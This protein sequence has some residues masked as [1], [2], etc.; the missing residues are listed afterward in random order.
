MLNERLKSDRGD[1]LSRFPHHIRVQIGD[2]L[3]KWVLPIRL[4]YLTI[5]LDSHEVDP[6]HQKSSPVK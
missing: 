1:I 5:R 3:F 2:A 4:R 6:H